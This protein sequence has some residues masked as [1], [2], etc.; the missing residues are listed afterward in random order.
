MNKNTGVFARAY[1]TLHGVVRRHGHYF[2]I[3]RDHGERPGPRGP[4]HAYKN[5][6][7]LSLRRPDLLYTEGF[8]Y[9]DNWSTQSPWCTQSA[10]CI[11][12]AGHAIDITFDIPG[13]HYFG[14]PLRADYVERNM[15]IG[16]PCVSVL[17]RKDRGLSILAEQTKV[18]EF[19]ADWKRPEGGTDH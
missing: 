18:A 5:S 2:P 19:M 11:D 4:D 17:L 1:R 15:K 16:Q 10:W 7:L 8:I 13:A 9:I 12:A 6:Y 14:I 3:A